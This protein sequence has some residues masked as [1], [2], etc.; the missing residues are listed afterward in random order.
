MKR[1]LIFLCISVLAFS[2]FT[3]SAQED[4]SKI[5]FRNRAAGLQAVYNYLQSIG[6]EDCVKGWWLFNEASGNPIDQTVNNNDLIPSGSPIYLQADYLEL[7][8]AIKFNKS[9]SDHFK[10]LPDEQTWLDMGTDKDLVILVIFKSNTNTDHQ[11]FVCRYGEGRYEL[12]I[13]YP[14]GV[15]WSFL[16][17]ISGNTGALT[18]PTNITDGN[19]HLGQLRVDRDSTTGMYMYLD[20]AREGGI[21]DPTGIGD[22]TGSVDFYVGTA[23]GS[24]CFMDGWV[25]EIM[26]L[27]GNLP[28][29]VLSDAFA[30]WAYNQAL[31][32]PLNLPK[33]IN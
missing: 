28:A 5:G 9:S 8:K 26:V 31:G 11:T 19:W 7:P 16:Q 25:S 24:S 12:R 10:I 27:M 17:G 20:G 21:K 33:K 13:Y 6:K 2:I 32:Y 23:N 29:I 3:A 4:F 18:G 30:L 15:L 14:P 1:R 22:M